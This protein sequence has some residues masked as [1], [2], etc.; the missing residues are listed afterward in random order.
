MFGPRCWERIAPLSGVAFVVLLVIH[1]AL[2][3]QGLPATSAPPED[4]IRYLHE[5]RFGY[6]V[7]TY[8]QGLAMVALLWFLASAC[9]LLRPSE[10]PAGRLTWVVMAAGTATV[11]MMAVH[12]GLLTALSL[13]ADRGLDP[14]LVSL[15]WVLAFVVTGLSSFP[16]AAQMLALGVLILRSRALPGWLGV[17]ALVNAGLWLVGGVGASTT[18]EPWG[19]LGFLA[20]LVWLVWTATASVMI[21]RRRPTHT[22][23]AV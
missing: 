5:G 14:G 22:N 3:L 11:G 23:A 12:I 2:A 18:D 4:V 13:L 19:S 7:A 8:L 6:Q 20:F 1:A 9:R 10:G 21:F 16:C 17:A 15:I